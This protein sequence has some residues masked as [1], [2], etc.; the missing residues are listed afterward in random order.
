MKIL[1]TGAAG[2]LGAQLE[3]AL[4]TAHEI[5]GADLIGD[6]AHH[7]DIADYHACRRLI[8][9]IQPQLLIHCAAWTDVNACALDPAK[10]LRINGI[11]THNLAAACARNDLPMLYVSSNEVF[12][13]RRTQPYAEYDAP[14]PLN[15]Y[16]YSKWYGER[17]LQQIHPRHYIVRTAW[18]FAHGGGNFV[19]AILSAAE[20]G[21]GAAGG[22]QRSRQS[23]LYQ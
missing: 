13:G 3:L 11:G 18:L 17:A 23:D 8:P 19:Q 10:A 7:I 14:N 16:A 2:K 20:G 1:I 12:D 21:H 15:A 6:V 5:V 4:S 9:A 22:R